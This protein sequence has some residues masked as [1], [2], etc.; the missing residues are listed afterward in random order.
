MPQYTIDVGGAKHTINSEQELNE[1]DFAEIA[2]QL[3]Q[4]S[5]AVVPSSAK[6]VAKSPYEA[7]KSGEPYT[8]ERTLGAGIQNAAGQ[9]VGAFNAGTTDADWKGEHNIGT[10]LPYVA[11]QVWGAANQNILPVQNTEFGKWMASPAENYVESVTKPVAG[12]PVA[13]LNTPLGLAT[14]GTGA[15]ATRGIPMAKTA[16]KTVGGLLSANMA[17]GGAERGLNANTRPEIARGGVE[18]VLGWLGLKYAAKSEHPAAIKEMLTDAVPE[19][20]KHG[21]DIP[22]IEHASARGATQ[23]FVR[24]LMARVFP[25]KYKDPGA[26]AKSKAVIDADNILGGYDD[27]RISL[28]SAETDLA[29]ATTPESIKALQEKVDALKEFISD[30]EKHQD[31]DA[32]DA[33]V[34]AAQ[35][36][37][38]IVADIRRWEQH[39]TPEMD[40]LYNEMR[41]IDPDLPQPS[42]GRYY[43]A[44]TNLLPD[45]QAEKMAEWY[46]QSKPMP[47]GASANSHMNPHAKR[48]PFARRAMLTDKYSHDVELG[49]INSFGTRLHEVSKQRMYDALVKSGAALEADKV[50]TAPETMHGERARRFT[51]ETYGGK[52]RSLYMPDSLASELATVLD[53]GKRPPESKIIKALTQVQLL[54][55]VD[56]VAHLKNLHTSVVNALGRSSVAQDIAARFPG[57]S[58]AVA[59]YDIA[60]VS[61]ELI[62]DTPEI[63]SEIASMA[64]TGNIRPSYPATGVNKI[65]RGQQLIHGVDTAVRVI[66][67]RRFSEIAKRGWAEDTPRGR[68]DFIQQV[69]EYNRRLMPRYQQWMRDSG[70]SP[71]IVAGKT[72]NRLSTRLVTGDPGFKAK[73]AG[74]EAAAR[75]IQL[76]TMATLVSV[77]ILINL[78]TTGRV[79]GRPGTPIGSIDTGKNTADGKPI[80]VDLMHITGHRRG[81]RRLG[82]DALMKGVQQGKSFDDILGDMRDGVVQT[83]LH[84]YV[85]P[86]LGAGYQAISGNRIDMR[87]NAFSRD[88]KTVGGGMQ[89]VENARA[90]MKNL[91]PMIYN[92]LSLAWGEQAKDGPVSR[93]IPS[94]APAAVGAVGRLVD[95]VATPILQAVGYREGKSAIG[96]TRDRA[97]IWSREHDLPMSQVSV[98]AGKYADL[99]TALYRGDETEAIRQLDALSREMPRRKVISGVKDSIM[100][101]YT[102]SDTNDRKFYR[103]LDD[104]GKESYR[105]AHV[106]KQAAV[107]LLHQLAR[108]KTDFEPATNRIAMPPAISPMSPLNAPIYPLPVGKP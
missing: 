33:T 91:N 32:L 2:E 36:D 5:S 85:G 8:G 16:L 93:A 37:P 95:S 64:K 52:K 18:T 54:S 3:S 80:T 108:R 47:E 96:M 22:F 41:G 23:P 7:G 25:D 55:A 72:F 66:L 39:V 106:D 65:T 20:A 29:K 12:I 105:K 99:K 97:Q 30:V 57:I 24:D 70:F 86:G 75:A 98:G 43:Q 38:S 51:I 90:A 14:L 74:A 19:A 69:G 73:T 34:R 61:R 84:P 50:A 94:N 81:L 79:G 13:M 6:K 53:I 76:S 62:A 63:R 89:T 107:R 103:S 101:P 9:I 46:D 48:D 92:Q 10:G 59:L 11:G 28:A 83:N 88:A 45:F 100:T 1:T 82:V 102:G 27:A 40:K 56:L 31:L 68:Y 49:L 78:S 77:P 26:M 58:S 87:A 67:N 60:K 44:R 104:D 15:L 42:R 4:S 21:V 71:F 35:Q 17:V